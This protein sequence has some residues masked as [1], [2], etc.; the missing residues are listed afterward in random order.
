MKQDK[1]DS[2]ILFKATIPPIKSAFQADGD[3]VRVT[4]EIPKQFRAEG[5]RLAGMFDRVLNVGVEEE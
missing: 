4:F 3:V 2:A 5:L 1:D